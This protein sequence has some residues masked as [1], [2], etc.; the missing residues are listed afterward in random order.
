MT[1]PL[2]AA[3]EPPTKVGTIE[4]VTEYKLPN[5]LRVILLPDASKPVV[6]VNLTVLVGSRH[7]GYGETGMAHLLEHMLFKGTPT[8]PN[9]PKAL[10]D[11][12]AGDRFNGTTSWDRTNYYETMPARDENLEFG[13]KLEA[14]RLVNSYVKREDLISE[15]TVVRNEFEA[16]ENSPTHILSQRMMAAAYEWHNYGK[17]TIGNRADIERVPIENLQAFYKKYYQ[18]D[19]ALLA[20]AGRFDE[21]KALDYV[22]QYFGPIKR[23]ARKLDHTYTEEPPQDG[24]RIAVLRRVGSIGATGVIYHIPAAVQED[25]AAVQVLEDCLTNEP[26]GRAY[27]ALVEAKK[28]SRVSG[29]AYG[30]H[31]PG[32][33]EIT[34]KVEDP[35]KVDAC[36]DALIETVEGLGQKP[37][38]EDEVAKSQ[39]R[40]QRYYD[41]L[42]AA[43]DQLVVELSNWTGAG[44]WRL[45]FL[46][47]DRVAKVTA[48]DVNRVAQ[49]YLVRSNRTVGVY[50]PTKAPERAHIPDTPAVATVLAGYKGRGE[51]AAGEAFEPTPENI[52]KRVTRGTLGSVKTAFLPKK[53]RGQMV[54]LE[55]NLRYGNEESLTGKTTAAELMPSM[56]T[57]GTQKHTRQQIHDELDRLGA[58]VF[59]TGQPGLLSVSVKV[60]KPNLAATLKLVAEM[61]REPVFP[62]KE[63]EVLKNERLERLR[64]AKTEPQALAVTALM[65]KLHDYPK[66]NV[67]YVPTVDEAIERLQ[68]VTLD[69]VS[70]VYH[71]QLGAAVGELAAVG[72]FGPNE[73]TAG[74]EPALTGWK[75]DVPYKR[76]DR[77]AKPVEKGE[78]IRIETPDKAN[79]VYFAGLTY[80]MTDAEPEYPALLIGNYLLGEAPLASRLSVRVRGEKGL[81]YGVGSGFTAH[82]IDKAATFHVFAITNP[83]NMPKVGA[84]VGEEINKFLKDGL[85]LEELDG[86]KKAFLEARKVERTDDGALAAELTSG[87]FVGRTFRFV[88]EQEKKIDAAT[89]AEVQKAFT[90]VLDPKKLV[91]VEAGD[92]KKAEAKP[93]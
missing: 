40:F 63:F 57:R 11:H 68:A 35:G 23:P 33:V 85:S 46:N 76:I 7:E 75:S 36:R 92:F 93:K 64:A 59:F 22:A 14:D 4:G 20:I 34:A 48:A 58:Q 43:S 28:A 15:M 84:L 1:A 8:H 31:D 72:D 17:S 62:E 81:S 41:E 80:P 26:G 32:F 18:P 54:E 89:P 55:L 10:R 29:N 65:R 9:V 30:L 19:N 70:E 13:V 45:F 87:L 60:K 74:L 83:V 16:G 67:R 88:A 51:V 77:P 73:V 61:L 42:L 90:R 2:T 91:I 49:K 47:R 66:E 52:E 12:G 6:T 3:D 5:G 21:Q 24:E 82:P 53:T 86:G 27:K 44:D 78:T 79:A 50:Y 56:L 37:I 25:Y 71:K 69:Q 39:Q 38:T